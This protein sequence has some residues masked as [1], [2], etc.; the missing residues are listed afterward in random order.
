MSR[1][2]TTISVS[3]AGGKT[4][5][6]S[7]GVIE[8]EATG[9]VDIAVA[10]GDTDI[11]V[12]IQPSASSQLYVL[13]LTSTYYSSDLTYVFSD[14][15]TDAADTLTLDGPQLFSAGNLGSVGVNP[16]HI[17]LTMAP[18]GEAATVSMFV[19]RDATP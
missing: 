17:K 3:I 12:E 11:T 7:S 18:G 9:N 19:A 1:V 14:G 16:T 10:P 6:A 4:I 15:T 5:T 2:T 8:A 13:L